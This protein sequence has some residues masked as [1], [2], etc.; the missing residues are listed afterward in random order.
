MR[1][2]GCGL[3]NA[4]RTAIVVYWGSIAD[5]LHPLRE[6]FPVAAQHMTRQ[7]ETGSGV[8]SLMQ[9]KY[10]ADQLANIGMQNMPSWS[11]LLA[12]QRPQQIERPDIGEWKH[13]WQFY[14]SDALEQ[15]E[16]ISLLRSLRHRGLHGPSPDRARIRSCSGRF[17]ATWLIA[18]PVISY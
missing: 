12:G 5:T 14:A 16:R 4:Q 11:A 3:R 15:H 9:A 6:R 1:L 17:G 10:A 2:G 7:L 13:G 8:N 18:L